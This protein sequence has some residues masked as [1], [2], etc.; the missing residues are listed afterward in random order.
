MIVR[1]KERE[2]IMENYN[3]CDG[4]NCEVEYSQVVV[5][6]GNEW[7][8]WECSREY[9]AE[10]EVSVD[11]VVSSEEYGSLLIS[12]EEYYGLV[13]KCVDMGVYLEGKDEIW[14]EKNVR[15]ARDKYVK[16]LEVAREWRVKFEQ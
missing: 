16:L 7:S 5:D 12:K 2:S 3:Y 14:N 15:I 13:G 11:G 8:Y 9:D 10:E 1:L 6:A 4:G